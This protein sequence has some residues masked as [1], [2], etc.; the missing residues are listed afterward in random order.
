MPANLLKCL[1]AA[2]LCLA[3]SAVTAQPAAKDT[4]GLRTLIVMFD[5]LRP[6]YIT[7]QHMP[8]LHAFGKK[9]SYGKH[10]HSVF[11]TV[12]RVNSASYATGSYPS[13]HGLL[14]N[15]VYFPQVDATKGLNTGEAAELMRISEATSGKLLLTPSLGEILQSAGHRLMVFSSGS[16]GQALLQNHKVSGGAVVNPDL[17]LPASLAPE[18]VR[19]IGPPPAA[20][21][22]NT[23]RHKWVTDAFCR[24]SLAPDGPLVSA[25][26]FS[27]PDATAHA[28]GI[29]SPKAMESIRIVDQQFGRI[30]DS[31][32]SRGLAGA[33]NIIVSTD[34]GFVTD[35]GKEN[36]TDFL[37][38]EGLKKDRESGD[39]VVAGGALYV[40]DH[41]E[42]VIRKI[43]S[44]L[45]AQEW[46]G[47]LFTR[48]AKPG[49]MKGFAEGTL[50]FESIHWNNAGR[51]ADI[52]VVEDWDDRRNAFGY[53]G[54]SFARGIA[55]HGGSSP[56]EIHI[57]LL[58]SGPGFKKA[59]E[60]NLPTSNVDIV[61][62][63]LHLHKIAVPP[64]MDGR[65]MGELLAE[66]VHPPA[67]GVKKETIKTS[68]K[69]AWGTYNLVLERSATGKHYY[70]DLTRVTRSFHTADRK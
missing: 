5:G 2:S 70:V 44:L 57:P 28:E 46:V 12:T 31:L 64:D 42:S 3:G 19:E 67:E 32:G 30:L 27:D 23:A 59:F 53:A 40:K 60:G 52:L 38:R 26:W 14:G 34:H 29:G 7:P 43:V 21:K 69:H 10:N 58:A 36:L 49:A 13:R 39:V 51:T 55:G 33:F 15:T 63:I 54:T 20:A 22:P 6:D 50:S 35:A 25:I 8:R 11:P 24:Y 9:G 4:A 56:Y 61:P 62:T 47:A 37:I 41:D 18:I 48:S 1:F 16:T 17:I 66:P 65:V 68:A 45:Q